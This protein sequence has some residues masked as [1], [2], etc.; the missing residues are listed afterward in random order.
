VSRKPLKPARDPR[1][2][3]LPGTL[4]PIA[5]RVGIEPVDKLLARYGGQRIYIPL[6]AER[7][8][9]AELCGHDLAAAL[10]AAFGGRM[11]KV[12]R[13]EHLS[14]R[15]KHQMIRD[16]KRTAN[17]IAAAWGMHV[18]SI[19]RIRG[20]RDDGQLDLEDWLRDSASKVA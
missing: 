5:E 10:A 2:E 14:T 17:E 11:L 4:R 13:G 9:I 18:D 19:H 1:I 15:R 7:S 12:P 16:D 20:R 8:E 3:L 6:G